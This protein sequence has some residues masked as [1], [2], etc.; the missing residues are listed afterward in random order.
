MLKTQKV[1]CQ[2]EGR[3]ELARGGRSRP[4]PP[5]TPPRP[6]LPPRGLLAPGTAGSP[7]AGPDT[8]PINPGGAG[9]GG[10]PPGLP[11]R[12]APPPAPSLGPSPHLVRHPRPSRAHPPPRREQPR[13]PSPPP[14]S[15]AKPDLP[16]GRRLRRRP[17]LGEA[18]IPWGPPTAPRVSPERASP[19]RLPQKFSTPLLPPAPRPPARPPALGPPRP[20]ASEALPARTPGRW[21]GGAA[22]AS[23]CC[24]CATWWSPWAVSCWG[25]STLPAARAEAGLPPP[26][27][28]APDHRARGRRSQAPWGAARV[29]RGR[30]PPAPREQESG[31]GQAR[32]S[33]VY[34]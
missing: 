15:P 33:S 4:R 25:P 21:R 9:A 7:R 24:C 8:K 19:P 2:G 31:C 1:S 6:R 16:L 20:S 11:F 17:R 5:P 10:R 32:A 28:P 23:C 34:L 29:R 12:S 30:L 22:T 14:R 3:K 18:D 26:G 13:P 27:P